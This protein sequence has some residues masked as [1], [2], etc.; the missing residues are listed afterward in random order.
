[1]HGSR[2]RCRCLVTDPTIPFG[3]H[4]AP[5]WRLTRLGAKQAEA[6]DEAECG[7]EQDGPG[8]GGKTKG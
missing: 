2:V 6:D 8:V 3:D 4:G 7:G 1:M 5:D